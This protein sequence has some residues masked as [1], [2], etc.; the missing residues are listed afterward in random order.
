MGVAQSTGGPKL[1]GV[2]QVAFRVSDVQAEIQLLNK[3]GFEQAFTYEQDGRTTSE[4]VKVNDR[5]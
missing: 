5:D 1:E 3:L 2:A 4:F